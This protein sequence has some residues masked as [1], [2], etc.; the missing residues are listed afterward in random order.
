MDRVER[1]GHVA[2]PDPINALPGEGGHAFRVDR[3]LAPGRCNQ[4]SITEGKIILAIA[5]LSSFKYCVM[6]FI[7]YIK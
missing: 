5:V 2:V 4:D 7:K 6:K 3:C 1:C